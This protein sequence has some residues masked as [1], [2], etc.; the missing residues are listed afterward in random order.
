MSIREFLTNDVVRHVSVLIVTV[1]GVFLIIAGVTI[2]FTAAEE[3]KRWAIRVLVGLQILV[4]L[5]LLLALFVLAI[6]AMGFGDAR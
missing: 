1:V 6:W 2:C 3:S 5:A 4:A